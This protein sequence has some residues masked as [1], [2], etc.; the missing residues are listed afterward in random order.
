MVHD[1]IKNHEQYECVTVEPR[2]I[3]ES[4][5]GKEHSLK[6]IAIDDDCY[7]FESS[8]ELKK[9]Q[10]KLACLLGELC[11]PKLIL[12]ESDVGSNFLVSI[13]MGSAIIRIKAIRR[14]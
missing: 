12:S 14:N 8:P 5:L 9:Y 2:V 4:I 11:N 1:I 10:K 13:K 3:P 7:I 6:L